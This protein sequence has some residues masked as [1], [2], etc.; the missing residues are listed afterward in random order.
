MATEVGELYYDLNIDDKKLKAQLS[1]ADKSVKSFGDRLGQHWDKS[2]NASKALAVGV[3]AAGAAVAAFGASSVKAY[4]AAEEAQTKLRTNMLNVKGATEAQVTSL[5]KLASQLQAVGVIEDDVIKA[6]MSQLA[7]FNLQSKTI[8]KLTPKI[9]DMVAQ[10]KGHNATTEDMVGINN[11]VGKVMTGNVGALSRYGVTLD[12]TQ[13]KVLTNG[14]ETERAAMLTKVLAQNY[15]SVNEALAKTPQGMITQLKN[16]FGDLQEGV[17]EFIISA[18]RPAL[19]WMNSFM[20]KVNEAGGVLEYLKGV[21]DRNK[22]SI[23]IMGAAIGGAL[24]PAFVALGISVATTLIHL[25]P[26]MLAGAAV[27]YLWMNN[28]P[29]LFS[30]AAGITAIGVALFVSAIPAMWAAVPAIWAVGAGVIAATWPFVAIGL[31][32][33]AATYLIITNWERVRNFLSGVLGWVR[34]NWPSLLP[35]LLGPFGAVIAPIIGMIG[36]IPGIISGG[37]A[38]A[39][40]IMNNW[41]SIFAAAGMALLDA[42]TGGLASRIGGMVGTVKNA[43][44]A[45][46]RMLPHSDAKEGPLSQL[47]LSGRRLMETMATGVRQGSGAF[48]ASVEASLNHRMI[49]PDQPAQPSRSMNIERLIVNDKGDADY[50]LNRLN[51]DYELESMGLSPL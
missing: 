24:V 22:E 7:T 20:G 45:I 34:G 42:F 10:L 49:M 14:N 23:I 46:A 50:V 8:E 27:A 37:L 15:G 25:A 16:N 38:A 35:I 3:A 29:L 4:F 40:A 1:G 28:K 13:K 19:E 5:G 32:V 30:I 51:R 31:A 18:A 2:V 9:T 48:Q 47:T 33:T 21:W 6:G 39:R 36:R 17:G 26:F 12:E 11:L 44:G 41:R 43:L